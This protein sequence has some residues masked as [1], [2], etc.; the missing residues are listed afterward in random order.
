MKQYELSEFLMY[1]VHG[2]RVIIYDKT[3]V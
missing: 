1:T 3:R 2:K